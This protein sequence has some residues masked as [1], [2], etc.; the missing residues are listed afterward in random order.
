MSMNWSWD[1]KDDQKVIAWVSKAS[2][3]ALLAGNDYL[4][5]EILLGASNF[6]ALRSQAQRV[7]GNSDLVRKW[8]WGIHYQI[9]EGAAIG[10]DLS[11]DPIVNDHRTVVECFRLLNSFFRLNNFGVQVEMAGQSLDLIIPETYEDDGIS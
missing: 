6:F 5:S 10:N 11:L 1:Q 4:A 2:E 3:D 9:Y 8:L 7:G